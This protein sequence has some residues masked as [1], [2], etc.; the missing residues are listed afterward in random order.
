MFFLSCFWSAPP[1]ATGSAPNYSSSRFRFF[2]PLPAT[3]PFHAYRNVGKTRETH[4]RRLWM[5]CSTVTRTGHS[6]HKMNTF[7][8]SISTKTYYALPGVRGGQAA[9]V[10]LFYGSLIDVKL[11]SYVAEGFIR[12]RLYIQQGTE[13]DCARTVQSTRSPRRSE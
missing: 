4:P 3:T 11:V 5:Q 1:A 8:Q 9:F 6:C 13:K 2:F 10:L 7:S 12:T